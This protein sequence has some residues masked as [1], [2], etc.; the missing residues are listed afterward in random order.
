MQTGCGGVPRDAG[1][2]TEGDDWGWV[3]G[4]CLVVVVCCKRLAAGLGTDA[5][6]WDN[7]LFM[8]TFECRK[9]ELRPQQC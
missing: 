8:A 3:T 1:T 4:L 2:T 6:C 7:G 9:L 5:P